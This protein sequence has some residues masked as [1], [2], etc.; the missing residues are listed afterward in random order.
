MLM[1]EVAFSVGAMAFTEETEDMTDEDLADAAEG[2]DGEVSINIE[3]DGT[4]DADVN[5]EDN[6]NDD[7]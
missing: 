5:V 1:S 6:T 7:D 3:I 2:G 4:A